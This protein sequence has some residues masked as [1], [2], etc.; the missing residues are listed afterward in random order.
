MTYENNKDVN[1]F[2]SF[3]RIQYKGLLP[4]IMIDPVGI[5]TQFHNHIKPIATKVTTL[6]MNVFSAAIDIVGRINGV[7]CN[8]GNNLENIM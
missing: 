6:T 3:N 8:N 4:L 5:T 7:I 1:K 2:E